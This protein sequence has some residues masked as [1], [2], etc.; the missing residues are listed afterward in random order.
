LPPSSLYR[1]FPLKVFELDNQFIHKSIFQT[2]TNNIYE[3]I[4]NLK[5]NGKIDNLDLI[6]YCPFVQSTLTFMQGNFNGIEFNLEDQLSI[7]SQI[8]GGA[9]FKNIIEN[10]KWKG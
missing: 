4:V 2:T 9:V 5:N 6:C 3:Y 8:P 1:Y 10:L 7:I